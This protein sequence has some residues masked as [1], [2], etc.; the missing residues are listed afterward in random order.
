MPLIRKDRAGKPEAAAIPEA[1]ALS[2]LTA[3]SA[4]AR[5]AA[6]RRAAELPGGIEALGR[7]LHV[8]PDPRVREAIFTALSR[9]GQ[10]ESAVAVMIPCLRSDDA[11][12]RAGALD[13]LRA[14]PSA[15]RVHLPLLL[16][17]RNPDVRLLACELARGLPA[18]EGPRLLAGLLDA[19]PEVNVCAAAV[20][21]L[22]EI[23]TTEALP[24]LQRCAARFPEEA[25]LGFSIKVAAD[26]IGSGDGGPR[27]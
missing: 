5:F 26:R 16:G 12:L 22:A 2:S 7:A 3:P 8:E 17:D 4:E 19:E 14:M 10:A 23:G 9:A 1:D 27:G 6:A 15:C 13:A 18:D 11:G 24:A 25:F 21:V 20:E